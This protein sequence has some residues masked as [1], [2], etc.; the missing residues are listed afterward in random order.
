MSWQDPL[1]V[2]SSSC[3]YS[4]WCRKI[5]IIIFIVITSTR[6]IARPSHH[7]AN[8]SDPSCNKCPSFVMATAR[9]VP[10]SAEY[11]HISHLKL[12]NLCQGP[13]EQPNWT[14]RRRRRTQSVTARTTMIK[15]WVAWVVQQQSRLTREMLCCWWGAIIGIFFM[16]MSTYWVVGG[17]G[18]QGCSIPFT[19]GYESHSVNEDL[20]LL[21]GCFWLV[22]WLR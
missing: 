20:V 21:S 15:R 10:R 17:G 22:S 11:C 2:A 5:V 9:G 19:L 3:R 8:A 4:Q 12:N 7:W 1:D 18:G 13:G 16:L 6:R 14:R